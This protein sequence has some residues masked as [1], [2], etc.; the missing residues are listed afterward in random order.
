MR[1]S[2]ILLA[3]GL[4]KRF[5]KKTSKPLVHVRGI[6]LILFSLKQLNVHPQV[7][8]I[9]VVVNPLNYRQVNSLIKKHRITK[10]KKIVLGGRLRQDSV[11]CGLAQI[12]S[13]SGFVLIHDSARP[14]IRQKEISSLLLKARETGAAILGVP[15]K[16]TIKKAARSVRSGSSPNGIAKVV[17]DETLDRDSLWEIQTPQVFAKELIFKA[18]KRFGNC[19][20]TDDAMLVEKSGARVSIV[21]GDYSNIKI[22]TPEDLCF[23]E[24]IAKGF[25]IDQDFKKTSKG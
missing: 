10:A 21:G 1:V 15:V 13:K 11:V 5:G 14:F 9:V 20:V 3:A 8:E 2:A 17:V 16:A 25:K 7:K 22:T 18:Y 24:V 6:P 19:Q 23:A 4:G 12:D